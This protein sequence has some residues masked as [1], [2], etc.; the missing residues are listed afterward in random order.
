MTRKCTV[1]I[2]GEMQLPESLLKAGFSKVTLANI[3]KT[4]CAFY[5]CAGIT[6]RNIHFW[7]YLP[8]Y[9]DK[10]LFSTKKKQLSANEYVTVIVITLEVSV[11]C[12]K[13]II[14]EVYQILS[15]FS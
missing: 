8:L 2:R 6:L 13:S 10:T 11:S 9:F 3:F 7:L 15:G 4:S 14:I 5:C 1:A 12:T